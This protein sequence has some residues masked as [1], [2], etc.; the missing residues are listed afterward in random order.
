MKNLT[1]LLLAFGLV[2][3]TLTLSAQNV[4]IN[5]DGSAPNPAAMLDI[6]ATNA[7]LLIPRMTAA[8]KEAISNSPAGLLVFQTDQTSGF[9]YFNGSTWISLGQNSHSEYLTFN[10]G[11]GEDYIKIDQ[12]GYTQL[13]SF[14]F[15]GTTIVGTPTAIKA[16][17]YCEHA[18]D[19]YSI[20]V[21]DTTNSNIIVELNDIAGDTT[22][23]H[24]LGPLN[25]LPTGEAIFQV[26]GYKQDGGKG[27]LQS[28]SIEY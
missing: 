13:G 17:S 16:V 26:L 11:S 20:M 1:T 28:I 27:R 9:K 15:R 7:G 2:I 22:E 21:Y 24:D 8:Q 18:T 5:R 25:N 12:N 3:T 14:I 23:I 4:A 10:N 19:P 6:S